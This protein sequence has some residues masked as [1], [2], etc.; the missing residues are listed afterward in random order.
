[1]AYFFLTPFWFQLVITLYLGLCIGSFL[2]VV[3][4][5]V[6]IG[7]ERR[8]QGL[9]FSI[10][11]P[12]SHCPVC[13]HTLQ[14]YENIPLLSWV[15]QKAKCRHCKTNI[16]WKYPTFELLVG[17]LSAG[18]WFYLIQVRNIVI[19]R[20]FLLEGWK[21]V[22]GEWLFLIFLQMALI[23]LVYWAFTRTKFHFYMLGWVAILLA[24][25]AG[26]G[27]WIASKSMIG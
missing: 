4:Y 1:M 2:N 13:G 16:S 8:A 5:R 9:K 12:R 6:P 11:H 25:A 21:I 10:S 24:F 14:W 18:I 22:F 17:L 26:A 7:V 27:W 23:P 20:T 19:D 3:L 15:I